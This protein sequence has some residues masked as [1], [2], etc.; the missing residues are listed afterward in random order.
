M[1]AGGAGALIG[2]SIILAGCIGIRLCDIYNER[3]NR[4]Y[5][6]TSIQSQNQSTPLLIRRTSHWKMNELLKQQKPNKQ[7]KSFTG[8]RILISTIDSQEKI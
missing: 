2:F 5:N 8:S 1:D 7:M 6:Y 4:R 3:K